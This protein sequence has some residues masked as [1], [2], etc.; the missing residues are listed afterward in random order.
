VHEPSW[1]EDKVGCLQILEGPSFAEDP[2]PEPP[3]C[4]LDREHIKQMIKE[5]NYRVKG[6]EKFW[7]DLDGTE[8]ILQVRAAVTSDWSPTS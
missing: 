6:T 3:K 2:H 4:F 8:S 7:N 5:F 1:H